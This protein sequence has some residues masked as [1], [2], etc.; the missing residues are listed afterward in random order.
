MGPN[1]TV[2][3]GPSSNWVEPDDRILGHDGPIL[4]SVGCSGPYRVRE[5]SEGLT[6]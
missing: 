1:W 6:I 4:G 3:P 2:E 5:T